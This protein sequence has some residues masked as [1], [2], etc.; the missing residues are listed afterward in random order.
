MKKFTFEELYAQQ[1]IVGDVAKDRDKFADIVDAVGIDPSLLKGGAET[2]TRICQV[3]SPG[4]S[5]K[6]AAR[7][8]L[9]FWTTTHPVTSKLCEKPTSMMSRWKQPGSLS[10]GF[11]PS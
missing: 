4:G 3:S 2:R 9:G 7:S 8:W 11:A 6:N 5:R 1:K 10:M